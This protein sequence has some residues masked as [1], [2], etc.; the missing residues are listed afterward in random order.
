MFMNSYS[1]GASLT[2]SLDIVAN[3]VSLI[4]PDGTLTGIRGDGGVLTIP[5]LIVAADEI[6]NGTL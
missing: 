3:S 5:G 4:N 1:T 2:N 6:V